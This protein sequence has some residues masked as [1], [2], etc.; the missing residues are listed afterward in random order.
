MSHTLTAASGVGE[1]RRGAGGAVEAGRCTRVG[2][3]VF[4]RGKQERRS[5][6]SVVIG[7]P[8]ASQCPPA[9][10]RCGASAFANDSHECRWTGGRI[11]GLLRAQS[12]QPCVPLSEVAQPVGVLIAQ[13][14]KSTHVHHPRPN[15][16]NPPPP[17][18]A[19]HLRG[20]SP[21]RFN[22]L[23]HVLADL[24]PASTA[25]HTRGATLGLPSQRAHLPQHG[26]PSLP[27]LLY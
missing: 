15:T 6:C 20:Q 14:P 19:P 7:S 1:L 4:R 13:N 26:A 22:A 5:F 3:E 9:T 21:L 27:P 25:E 24:Q 10:Y 17:S 12:D 2:F 8:A 23:Q 11:P 18:W 16:E